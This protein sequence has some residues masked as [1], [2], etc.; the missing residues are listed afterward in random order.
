MLKML[1]VS[2]LNN[3][4]GADFI[5]MEVNKEFAIPE[6]KN[7]TFGAAIEAL[8]AGYKV[9]RSGWNG[10]GMHLW[11]NKG[12][13]DHRSLTSQVDGSDIPNENLGNIA[14]VHMSLFDKGGEGTVTRFPNLNMKAAGGETV[15]G[16]LASQTDMLAEDWC[17]VE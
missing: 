13:I 9:A 8:K 6:T 4:K 14:G 17:I 2:K 11:L 1:R 16:W 3:R 5:I 10:K 7:I 12:S 15:T